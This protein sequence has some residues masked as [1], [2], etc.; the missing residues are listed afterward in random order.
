MEDINIT[1]D[2]LSKSKFRS[3]FYLNKKM[4]LYVSLKGLSLVREHAYEI[5]NKRLK[6]AIILND[7][8]Q[9]PMQQV[10]PVFIAQHACAC[11]CRNCL[12]KWHKIPK[13]KELTDEEVNYIVE[14]IMRWISREVGDC[15]K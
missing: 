6:P 7:G 13:V 4:K 10:H 3:S 11:C 1:L 12:F 5:I 8:K 14:L 9:T 15:Y 2:K